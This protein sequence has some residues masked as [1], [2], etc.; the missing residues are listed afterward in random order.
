MGG[1]AFAKS[2]KWLFSRS[3]CELVLRK[4]WYHMPSGTF[5]TVDELEN[6]TYISSLVAINV[7]DL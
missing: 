3:P 6:A 5:R 4:A 2:S 1:P 7:A